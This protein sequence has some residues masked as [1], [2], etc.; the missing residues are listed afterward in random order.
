MPYSLCAMDSS[1]ARTKKQS[2]EVLRTGTDMES[3]AQA[4]PLPGSLRQ[5]MPFTSR[6]PGFPLFNEMIL[7]GILR[8]TGEL[9]DA[10]HGNLLQ[11]N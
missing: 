3:D 11:T 2:C 7:T 8:I 4:P 6:R 9:M 10:E 1:R 5:L